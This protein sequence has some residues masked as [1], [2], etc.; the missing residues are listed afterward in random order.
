[1]TDTRGCPI[2]G[3]FTNGVNYRLKN[4]LFDNVNIAFKGV[5]NFIPTNPPVEYSGQY[6]ENTIWTNLP[7]YGFYLRHATNVTFTNCFTSVAPAD[8]RPWLATNDVSPLTV[9]G[10]VLNVLPDPA[11]LVL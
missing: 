5:L 11:N 7:A 2:T 10:P 1:M 8:A 3:C 6:P 9:F 4:I